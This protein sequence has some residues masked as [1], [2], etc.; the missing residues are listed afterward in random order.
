MDEKV[1]NADVYSVQEGDGMGQRLVDSEGEVLQGVEM[2]L[3]ALEA[4]GVDNARCGA[5]RARV[6]GEVWE[7][8][9]KRGTVTDKFVAMV[10]GGEGRG[11]AGAMRLAMHM[12][13]PVSCI[14]CTR[15]L[16]QNLFPLWLPCGLS[17]MEDPVLAAAH[18]TAIP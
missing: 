9:V 7:C 1:W 15:L 17:A 3:S 10:M 12:S 8:G 11:S 13:Y 5:G 4:C 18:G 2:L 14:G 6:W 16:L